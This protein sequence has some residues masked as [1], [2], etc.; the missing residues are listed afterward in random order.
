MVITQPMKTDKTQR[1]DVRALGTFPRPDSGTVDESYSPPPL[2][3]NVVKHPLVQNALSLLRNKHTSTK[4]FRTYSNQLLALLTIEAVRTLPTREETVETPADSA[5]VSVLDKPVVFLSLTRH[6]L[7]LA[8]GIAE[9]VP[10]MS[11]G[12]INIDRGRDGKSPE[13]R[14]HLVN[15]PMLKD[16]RVIVFDPIVGAGYSASCALHAVR[17][18]G[19]SDLSLLSFLISSPGL[20]RIQMAIP[21]L[22]VWTAAVDPEL[23]TKHGPMPGMGNFAERL[24]G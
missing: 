11:V 9:F 10:G 17:S 20:N 15:A 3:I 1:P 24:Y 18:S 16:A 23:D 12:S 5:K 6:G 4:Q 2:A 19:A 13:P 14:V 22:T 7:G 8:H 21:S